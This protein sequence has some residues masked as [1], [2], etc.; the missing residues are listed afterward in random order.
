MQQLIERH[1]AE[2]A[3]E[4]AAFVNEQIYAIKDVVESEG[5]D[6]EFELRRSYDVFLDESE[7][8]EAEKLFGDSLKTKQKWTRYVDF[9]G[10]KRAEQ[11]GL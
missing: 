11:V 5:L 2:A 9:V 7:A 1:G 10:E 4:I 8:R 6:C 3:Q